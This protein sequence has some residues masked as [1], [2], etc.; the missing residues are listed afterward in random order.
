MTGQ[1]TWNKATTPAGTDP[2]NYVPAVKN[3]LETA[4]LVFSV[5]NATERNA[6]AASAPGGV[7]PVPTLVFQ[8]DDQHFKL[9]NGTGWRNFPDTYTG[10]GNNQPVVKSA[11]AVITTGTFG[12]FTLTLPT[13][14]PNGITSAVVQE[15]S[16]I[17]NNDYPVLI[18]VRMDLMDK[19]KII[20]RCYR[21][22]DS[23]F[24]NSSINVTYIAWGY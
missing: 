6:L 19:T 10:E 3:A 16:T 5:A 24:A 18:K 4:G 22:D 23:K 21:A 11:Q 14:F 1:T 20:G 9:W 8:T 12:D 7:L 15:A 17:A 13:A 2:W